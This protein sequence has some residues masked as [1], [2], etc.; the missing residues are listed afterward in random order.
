MFT[1]P[2]TAYKN[3]PLCRKY[4]TLSLILVTMSLL[5]TLRLLP[6]TF[7]VKR[8]TNQLSRNYSDEAAKAQLV[9]AAAALKEPT[10]FDK[11]I[12]KEIPA[13]IIY[14]DD[15]CLAFRDISPQAPVHFL[16]IPKI[17]IARLEDSQESD[18]D[19]SHHLHDFQLHNL[20]YHKPLFRSWAT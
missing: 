11:I 16:V 13:T 19:V 18:K 17:R 1:F 3:A 14:E 4:P 8:V 2:G 7:L 6:R 5:G 15:K 20:D 9:Q 12:S 10:I